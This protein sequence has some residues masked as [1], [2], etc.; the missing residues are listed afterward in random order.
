MEERKAQCLY[1]SQAV[2]KAF[3]TYS[4]ISDKPKYVL[5]ENAL[6]EYMNNHPIDGVIINVP[7]SPDF[8]ALVSMVKEALNENRLKD[9]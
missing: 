5:V 3:T 1:L 2:N 8:I 9:V 4:R 6:I 7:P